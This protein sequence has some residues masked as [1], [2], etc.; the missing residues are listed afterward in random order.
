MFRK[1]TFTLCILSLLATALPSAGAG[2]DSPISGIN[3]CSLLDAETITK[4]VGLPVEPG[5]RRDTGRETSGAYSSTCLWVIRFA[6]SEVHDPDA[7]LG[8]RGFAI[9]N[10]LTWQTG[11]GLA[12]TFLDAFHD[13][14]KTGLIP[15]VPEARPFGDRALWWG[16]GMAVAVAD[17]SFGLSIYTPALEPAYPGEFEESLTPEILRQLAEQKK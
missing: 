7:P 3:A 14:A 17:V 12:G 8:G 16:D 10:V 5:V 9:L 13:A 2:R 4:V 1:A 11:S 15:S 6:G